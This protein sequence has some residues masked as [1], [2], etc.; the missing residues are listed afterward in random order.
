MWGI[1]ITPGQLGTHKGKR[2]SKERNLSEDWGRAEQLHLRLVEG[3]LGMGCIN[4]NST[5]SAAHTWA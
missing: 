4:G 2:G 3:G 5:G 1:Y